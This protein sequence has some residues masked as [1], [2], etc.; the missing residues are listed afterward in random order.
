MPSRIQLLFVYFAENFAM[1]SQCFV[2]LCSG[3]RDEPLRTSAWE[4]MFVC[5]YSFLA[6]D[7][8][9]SKFSLACTERGKNFRPHFRKR[10]ILM[11]LDCSSFCFRTQATLED[12]TLLFVVLW[13]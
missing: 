11:F 8:A 13:L 2:V 9:C 4:A 5:F 10:Q 12:K 3:T 7:A 6:K 1:Y